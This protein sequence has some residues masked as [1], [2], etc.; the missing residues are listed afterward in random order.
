MFWNVKLANMCMLS[1]RYD[2]YWER[3]CRL[4]YRIFRSKAHIY[5]IWLF[6]CL[7][8]LFNFM[9]LSRIIKIFID[10]HSSMWILIVYHVFYLYLKTAAYLMISMQNCLN[11]FLLFPL[12][13]AFIRYINILNCV[14]YDRSSEL[15]TCLLLRK[16][17]LDDRWK[18]SKGHSNSEVKINWQLIGKNIPNDKQQ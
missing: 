4:H 5:R 11:L 16:N 3:L 9:L 2:H 12:D 13:H 15:L 17:P 18:T 10:L 8:W 1:R 14:Q 7:H 6:F